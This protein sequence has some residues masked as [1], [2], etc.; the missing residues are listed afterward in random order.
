MKIQKN[1]YNS[2]LTVLLLGV[3]GW[4]IL[5]CTETNRVI[6]SNQKPVVEAFLAP[7]K[8]INLKLTTVIGYS[9]E[10]D[11]PDSV[12]RPIDGQT[13]RINVSNGEVFTLKSLGEGLYESAAN[14]L[15]KFGLTYTLDF[16]YNDLPISATTT[17]P[18]RPTG[19]TLSRT[20]IY[21]SK[22]DLSSGTSGGFRPP[23]SSA[24]DRIPI[25]A[26]WN[27]ATKE[28]HFV[29]LISAE[30]AP[31]SIVILPT[32]TS[33]PFPFARRFNN[34]PTTASVSQ[35]QPQSFQYFGKH[36]A[37][38]YRL[39]PDYAALYKSG[40]TTTQNISTPP[41]SITNGLGIFTGVNADTLIVNVYKI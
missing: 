26:S 25:E 3:G 2:I 28:Y 20:I 27:N 10:A 33:N 14:Q 35:I 29:A 5:A 7:G 37:V 23:G 12:S 8:P 1:K 16:T 36:Y 24:E 6:Y 15:V 34:E 19:F 30:T 21:R 39:N 32:D 38:L 18:T 22:I 40:G 31:E 11:A 4:L 17:I 41:T 9:E 13:I